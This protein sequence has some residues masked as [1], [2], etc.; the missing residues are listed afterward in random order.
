MNPIM[1]TVGKFEFRWYSI[2]ILIGAIIAILLACKEAKRFGIKSD[3][4]VNLAF[5]TI[6]FGII[7]ARLYYVL[8]NFELYKDNI[9]DVIK[10]WNG[11]LAIHG[12]LLAGTIAAIIYTKKCNVKSLKIIDIAIPGVILAQAIGRWGNFFNSEAHGAVTTLARLKAQHIPSFIIKG[13][14]IGGFYYEPTF[15]YESLWCFIGF[16]I[17]IYLRRRKYLKVGMLTW[18]Y[19][20]WYGV[21]RFLIESRRTDSLMLGGF[22]VAQLVSIILFIIGLINMIIAL[23]KDKYEDL[24]NGELS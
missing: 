3:F 6:I 20:M 13:M 1:F 14:N 5:Y 7:G 9:V 12:G 22:K 4:I 23:R 17:L 16:I 19:L 11:G 10:V 18:T 2:L 15:F 21:G 24:Y 8:F